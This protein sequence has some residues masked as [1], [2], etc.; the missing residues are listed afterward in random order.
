MPMPPRQFPG[1]RKTRPRSFSTKLASSSTSQRNRDLSQRGVQGRPLSESDDI[2][3]YATQKEERRMMRF[4]R[5][6]QIRDESGD[7]A[8]NGNEIGVKMMMRFVRTRQIC[9]ESDRLRMI[10]P[11]GRLIPNDIT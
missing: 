7:N 3:V 10:A 9:D 4:V 5:M 2:Y 1:D 11:A 8:A 6:R